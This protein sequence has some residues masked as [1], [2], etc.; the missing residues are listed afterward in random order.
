MQFVYAFDFSESF[1]TKRLS[2]V[3]FEEK[4]T[5]KW[6]LYEDAWLGLLMN[7]T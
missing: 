5:S 7:G 1:S 2:D 4:D 6:K 3:E